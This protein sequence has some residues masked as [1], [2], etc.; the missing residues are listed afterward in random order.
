M[1]PPARIAEVIFSAFQAY[2]ND[3]HRITQRARRHFETRDWKAGQADAAR[4]I[5]L[6][7]QRVGQI[8]RRLS[9]I[10]DERQQDRPAWAS[11]KQAYAVRIKDCPDSEFF[12]TFFNSITR[13]VF[14][15]VGVAPDVEFIALDVTPTEHIHE[16]MARRIYQNRGALQYLIDELLCDFAFSTPYRDITRSIRFVTAEINAFCQI[17]K[18]GG[19]IESIELIEPV[20]FRGTRSYLVG[21]LSGE[22]W[23]APLVLALK[24]TDEGI[25]IDAVIISEIDV[26]MLFGFT[27]SYF[28]VDLPTVGATVSFL[29][30]IL[31]RKPIDEIYTVLGRAKQGKT[32]RYRS[33]FRHLKNSDDL[34]VHAPGTRGMVMLVFT[35]PSYDIVFK[36]IRDQFAYPKSIGRED[37]MRK[38]QLVFKHDRAGRLV[39]AQEFRQLKFPKNRFSTG[40]LNDLL[41]EG[42]QSCRIEDDEILIE[43]C[44]IERR[45]LPLNIFLQETHAAE[46]RD[47]VIDYGQAI[48][49]LARSNIF[50]GDLLLKNF[51]LTRHGRVIFYVY[52]ELCFVTDCI[53]RDLP[54][55]RYEED[56]MRAEA[57]FYVG[58][59]DIF[60]EQFSQFLAF[61]GELLDCFL[62][63]HADL[64]TSSYWREIKTR[65]DAGEVLEVLPYTARN[66]TE[67]RGQAYYPVRRGG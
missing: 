23:M 3:F 17:H 62:A 1:P 29:K 22:D 67:H 50:P 15:T 30:T 58:P 16:A 11:I 34:F 40:L 42:S 65:I 27:R 36:I 20:F 64:F 41:T 59:N 31:P 46:A 57:W 18:S 55:A 19:P 39:D 61:K 54:R 52:D 8:V 28:H 13:R 43:H 38:Y 6:Y 9:A 32:E 21:R 37:V 56:E 44:Y 7:D 4:R 25:M 51:G 24:N 66:W 14:Q 45:L 5:D 47:V 63:H 10:L 12:K 35:L 2:N 53:F 49:D 33:F 26:S 60:P 48:R